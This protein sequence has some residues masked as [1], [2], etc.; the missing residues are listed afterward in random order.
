MTPLVLPDG[1]IFLGADVI[2]RWSPCLPVSVGRRPLPP[3]PALPDD[4]EGLDV[5]VGEELG[6]NSIHF[7]SL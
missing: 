3:L 4:E 6:L 7:K 1:S 2:C 5:V